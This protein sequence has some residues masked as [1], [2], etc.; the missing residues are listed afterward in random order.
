MAAW[1]ERARTSW[2]AGGG[3]QQSTFFSVAVLVAAA[4][5][6]SAVAAASAPGELRLRLAGGVA[7]A[8]VPAAAGSLLLLLS[9]ASA[10]ASAAAG[11][12]LLRLTEAD[13]PRLPPALGAVF[14]GGMVRWMEKISRWP[15]SKAQHNT[16]EQPHPR[17]PALSFPS[18]VVSSIWIRWFWTAGMEGMVLAWVDLGVGVSAGCRDGARR[19]SRT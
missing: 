16:N 3:R 8:L 11:S 7:A 19:T 15:Q 5:P 10:A 2:T 18:M 6:A 13:F 14:F 1:R 12:V 17:P 4:A 9:A